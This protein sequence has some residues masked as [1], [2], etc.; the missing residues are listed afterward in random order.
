MLS[1]HT[2]RRGAAAA[3][4]PPRRR[5]LLVCAIHIDR[6]AALERAWQRQQRAADLELADPPRG[7]V[8]DVSSLRHLEAVL[9]RA[10]GSGRLVVALFYSRSCGSCGRAREALKTL[11]ADAESSRTRAA[12]VC[13]D[14]RDEYDHPSAAARLYGVR[15]VP[16]FLFFSDGALVRRLSL[17]DVRALAHGRSPQQIR[18]ALEEDVAGVRTAYRAL[19]L[20]AAPSAGARED[21]AVV[22]GQQQQRQEQQPPQSD[23]SGGGEA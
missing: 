20:R 14:V 23:D 13:V 1:P 8:L 3:A 10:A 18:A 6:R 7:G 2:R 16:A 19:V 5:R 21:V 9:E 15:S 4:A 17:R 22:V 12:F 11:A